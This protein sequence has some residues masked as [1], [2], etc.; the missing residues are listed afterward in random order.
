MA[1]NETQTGVKTMTNINHAE[2][3]AKT[4]NMTFA[5][6]LYVI[7]DCKQAIAAMPEGHKAGYY[8]DEINYCA[9]EINRRAKGKK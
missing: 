9:M 3:E 4:R 7:E 6:L 2:Y 8:A 1:N 5:S